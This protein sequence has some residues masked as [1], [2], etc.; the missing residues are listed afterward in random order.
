MTER[1]YE[2]KG[3]VT[4][5]DGLTS[6][7]VRRSFGGWIVAASYSPDMLSGK[8]VG[9]H[10]SPDPSHLREEEDLEDLGEKRFPWVTRVINCEYTGRPTSYCDGTYSADVYC[11]TPRSGRNRII[12]GLEMYARE[13]ETRLR[14]TF[15]L[16]AR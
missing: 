9:I 13:E 5:P 10:V 16:E 8:Y 15:G 3:E 14:E 6:S 4:T 11:I 7:L 2:Q 1:W 12:R